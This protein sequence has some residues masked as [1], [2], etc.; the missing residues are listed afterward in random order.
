MIREADYSDIPH[1]VEMGRR[2][3]ELA[4]SRINVPFDYIS[5]EQ[6]LSGMVDNPDGVVLTNDDCTAMFGAIVH[7]WHFNANVKTSTEM[8]WWAENGCRDG[9]AMRRKGEEMVQA[10]GAKSMNMANQEHMRSKALARLYR[11]EG[12]VLSENIFIKEFA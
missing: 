9:L 4:Y 5:T 12:F 6:L 8:F 2:F 7:S 1:L 3:V 11:M 10:L